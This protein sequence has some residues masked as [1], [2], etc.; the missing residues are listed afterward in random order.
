MVDKMYKTINPFTL[1]VPSKII[2]CYSH[3]F[4]NNLVFK[5][6]FTKY[7]NENCVVAS[8]KHLS[9]KCF[10]KNAFLSKTFLKLSGLFWLL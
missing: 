5:G 2:V 7:L 6:N 9:M 8:D 3:T 10:S 4:E 1:R